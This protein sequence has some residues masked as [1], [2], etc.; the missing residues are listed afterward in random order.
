MSWESAPGPRPT[1]VDELR[2]IEEV[3]GSFRAQSALDLTQNDALRLRQ[4]DYR[5]QHSKPFAREWRRN[6][7]LGTALS[8]VAL[9]PLG[10]AFNKNSLG[11][12]AHFVPKVYL[13]PWLPHP[14]FYRRWKHALWT[15]PA[16]LAGGLLFAACRTSIRPHADELMT[17]RRPLLPGHASARL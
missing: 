7:L 17:A 5:E 12:P 10:F 14:H 6:F 2:L 8:A 4:I 3:K 15:G 1:R 9:V 13:A 16:V 11:V